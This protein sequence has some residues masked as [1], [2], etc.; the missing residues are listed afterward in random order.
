L[1]KINRLEPLHIE[2]S[3]I[4]FNAKI[5]LKL[6]F[7]Y[8]NPSVLCSKA[9]QEYTLLQKQTSTNKQTTVDL[10]KF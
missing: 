10:L 1:K 3:S 9:L 5:L 8:N 2:F 6:F 7:A 4:K